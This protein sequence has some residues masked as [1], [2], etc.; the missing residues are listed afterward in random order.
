E[1]GRQGSDVFEVIDC[2]AEVRAILEELVPK[3]WS[4]D[5]IPGAWSRSRVKRS[6]SPEHDHE[7]GS[8]SIVCVTLD[9][10]PP[11]RAD[12]SRSTSGSQ[13]QPRL[14]SLSCSFRSLSDSAL[15]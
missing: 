5:F 2:Q 15:S 7:H 10:L 9:S 6:A 1:I 8:E 14:R 4:P 3:G 11:C 12:A 13:L